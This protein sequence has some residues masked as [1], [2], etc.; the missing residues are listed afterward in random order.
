MRRGACERSEHVRRHGTRERCVA[1]G[2]EAGRGGARAG[3]GVRPMREAGEDLSAGARGT[4]RG[5]AREVGWMARSVDSM[6]YSVCI[7]ILYKK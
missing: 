7:Y 1:H 2:R 6:V 3:G 5:H 4:Q